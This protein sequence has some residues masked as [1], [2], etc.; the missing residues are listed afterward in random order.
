MP[1]ISPV[2]KGLRRLRSA[3]RSQSPRVRMARATLSS[4]RMPVASSPIVKLA[5]PTS[6][7][8]A[9]AS[10][11]EEGEVRPHHLLHPQTGP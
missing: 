4:E 10:A 9:S 11:S 6:V 2:M 3:A 7:A 1:F 8:P 5:A